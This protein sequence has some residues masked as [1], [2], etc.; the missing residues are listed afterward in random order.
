LNKNRSC[1]SREKSAIPCVKE[2]EIF[3]LKPEICYSK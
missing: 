3:I 1:F 2:I